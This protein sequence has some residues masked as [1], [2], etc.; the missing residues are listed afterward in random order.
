MVWEN[1]SF[2]INNEVN[3]EGRFERQKKKPLN[4]FQR[5]K[6]L[7]NRVKKKLSGRDH[8]EKFGSSEKVYST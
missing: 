2:I 6:D 5:V 3:L 8:L 7:Y 1:K 4:S